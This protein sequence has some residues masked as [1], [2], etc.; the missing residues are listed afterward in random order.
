M[1]A[2]GLTFAVPGVMPEAMAANANLFVS[3]ENSQFGNIMSGPQVV[4]VVVIDS[5]INQT[6]ELVG[7]PDVT[8]NGKQLRMAQ[9]TDGNW[10]GYFAEVEQAQLADST[11]TSTAQTDTMGQ[12]LDFGTF[13]ASTVGLDTFGFDLSETN[14]V[15]V[16]SNFGANGT[17]TAVTTITTDCSAGPV[18]ATQNGTNNVVREPKTIQTTTSLTGQIGFNATNYPRT[19]NGDQGQTTA[20]WPF[21]QLYD[22]TLG[23]NVV[24]AYNKAGGQQTTTLLFDE[25]SNITLT[26]DRNVYPRSAEVHV[27]IADFWLNIDPTDED[28]WTFDV[29]NGGTYYAEFAEDGTDNAGTVANLASGGLDILENLNNSDAVLTINTAAQGQTAIIAYDDNGN[30]VL[31]GSD[32]TFLESGVNTGIFTSYDEDDDSQIGITATAARGTSATINY[33]DSDY[34]I[35][36]RASF[37]TLEMQLNDDEWN[38]GESI[39]VVLV[40]ADANKNSRSDEDLDNE[41]P[42][43]SLIPALVTGDPFTIDEAGDTTLE[44]FMTNGT[45]NNSLTQAAGLAAAAGTVN[46]VTAVANGNGTGTIATQNFSHR[47][48]ATLGDACDRSTCRTS[49]GATITPVDLLIDLETTMAELKKSINQLFCQPA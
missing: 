49:D 4:E 24:I 12:G 44:F 33:D 9:A 23:G 40:D 42:T 16:P 1:V 36:T 13:C 37:A 11:N 29:A 5:D 15:A 26:L 7:E 31:S 47:G 38:S 8:I 3:A 10:Y 45:G 34:S 28:S 41:N 21:I 18:T 19:N 17:T 25:A 14:G 43:V 20:Y 27:E 2:G 32:I 30:S 35:V 48:L 39:D 22:F 6:D 46:T